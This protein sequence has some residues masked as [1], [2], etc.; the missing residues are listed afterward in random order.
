MKKTKIFEKWVGHIAESL[1]IQMNGGKR[2]NNHL[3]RNNSK[4]NKRSLYKPSGI[5]PGNFY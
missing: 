5:F 3:Q 1:H 2:G 4:Q